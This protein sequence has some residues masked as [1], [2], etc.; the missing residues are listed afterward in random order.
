MDVL[1]NKKVTGKHL[2]RKDLHLNKA[3]FSR[4]AKSIIYKSRKFWC[5]LKHLKE[6]PATVSNFPENNT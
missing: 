1:D 5:P 6:S 2:G 3:D 4:L